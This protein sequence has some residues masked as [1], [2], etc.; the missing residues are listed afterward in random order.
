TCTNGDDPAENNGARRWQGLVEVVRADEEGTGVGAETRKGMVET[1]HG[2]AV[3]GPP[4]SGLGL[5]VPTQEL[6][7]VHHHLAG[8]SPGVA[9]GDVADERVPVSVDDRAELMGDDRTALE[10][11]VGDPHAWAITRQGSLSS[12]LATEG[13]HAPSQT[14]RRH[15]RSTGSGSSDGAN[16]V[17]DGGVV[18]ERHTLVLQALQRGGTSDVAIH[19]G[20]LLGVTQLVPGALHT[21]D[22]DSGRWGDRAGGEV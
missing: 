22:L 19:V 12:T 21:T 1:I 2:L 5:V 11:G 16:P 14:G 20:D 15:L 6:V 7:H 17:L 18:R 9:L 3:G 4:V 8:A 10:R 13:P